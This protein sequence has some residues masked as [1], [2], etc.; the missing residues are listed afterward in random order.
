MAA[1]NPKTSGDLLAQA[2]EQARRLWEDVLLRQAQIQARGASVD[3]ALAAQELR[4]LREVA[5]A[6][7]ELWE[8]MKGK[9]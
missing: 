7:R 8:E 4:A 2:E 3:A 6:A 5:E 1:E 9:K